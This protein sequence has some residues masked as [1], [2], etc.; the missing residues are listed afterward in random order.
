MRFP[1]RLFF[2]LYFMSLEQGLFMLNLPSLSHENFSFHEKSLY[3]HENG[4]CVVEK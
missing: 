3:L 1:S 4:S 2:Y